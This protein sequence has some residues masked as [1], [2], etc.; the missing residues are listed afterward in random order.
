MQPITRVHNI[1]R[2]R[3]VVNYVTRLNNR[4][5]HPRDYEIARM[6]AETGLSKYRL[7]KIR[8]RIMRRARDHLLT[9]AYIGL[10][11]RIGKPFGYRST[12]A[13]RLLYKYNPTDECPK[14][15]FE[16]AVFIDKIMRMKLT[17]VY[18]LQLGRQ[19]E[20]FRSRPCLYILHVLKQREW[21][22][23]HQIAVAN[24]GKRCDPMLADSF[25]KSLLTAVC[26]YEEMN[27][28]SLNQFYSDFDIGGDEMKN[29]TRNIRPLLDWCEAVGLIESR[30]YRDIPGRWYKLSDR[31]IK[32]LNRYSS[33]TPIWFI[34]LGHAPCFKAALLILYQYFYLKNVSVRKGFLRSKVTIGLLETSVSDTLSELRQLYPSIF[35]DDGYRL[36][37]HIDFT[38][39]YDVPP[40][41]R[42][43]VE[44]YLRALCRDIGIKLTELLFH[45]GEDT[46]INLS[47][48]LEKEYQDTK[49]TFAD[50]L[51]QSLALVD[52]SEIS[53]V[54]EA[55]P[56]LG[57]LSQYRSDFEKE[58]AI[59]L[60][61]LGLNAIKYQGQLA[62]RCSKPYS[63]RFFENNPDILII[64]DVEC[65]VECKSIGEWQPPLSSEKSVVKEIITYNQFLT[66]IRRNN[67]HP[68]SIVIVY[69]GPLDSNSY[70]FIENILADTKNIVFIT[71]NF[72]VNCVDDRVLRD[73]MLK[74]IKMPNIY[75]AASR[76]LSR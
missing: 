40:E 28:S 63:M 19:Y 16:E 59:L 21:M 70:R 73:K 45:L 56:S 72:L 46:I 9:A 64:N 29:M 13:G 76:I 30:Q 25:T 53:K 38:L 62:D 22:H 14:D 49:T 31:G 24:G 51:S 18:D 3:T 61:L 54:S 11:T 5:T 55:I 1:Y 74:I 12:Y 8:D 48:L 65:L 71:K 23:E 60:K 10:L 35:S 20:E 68:N 69:E 34:D 44:D 26:S 15:S 52:K 37:S 66:E 7:H 17:N 4:N 42:L 2:I 39:S 36:K 32:I 41:K 27:R 6:L 58:T 33:L 50:K 57:I 47:G 75:D 43:E 67:K